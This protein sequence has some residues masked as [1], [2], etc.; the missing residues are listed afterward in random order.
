MAPRTSAVYKGMCAG[1]IAVEHVCTL[2]TELGHA[3][4]I[5]EVVTSALVAL[6]SFSMCHGIIS[7]LN[8]Q[9]KQIEGRKTMVGA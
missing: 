6:R 4:E 2:R 3:R 5:R 7:H 8:P 1:F 9:I